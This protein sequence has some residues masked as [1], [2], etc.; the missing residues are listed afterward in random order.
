MFKWLFFDSEY[1]SLNGAQR[2][3]AHK[4]VKC[5]NTYNIIQYKRICEYFG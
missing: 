4:P 5:F 3:F 2:E 1:H